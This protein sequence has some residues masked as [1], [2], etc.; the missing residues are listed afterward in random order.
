M[1]DVEIATA[2]VAVH[3]IIIAFNVLGLFVI[4]LGAWLRLAHL[5]LLAIVAGQALMGRACILTIWQHELIGGTAAPQPMIMH[6]LDGLIY[7]NIPIWVFSIIYT[8]VFLYVVAL[9]LL[10]PFGRADRS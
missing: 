8:A 4:P 1:P 9:S 10:V 6:W 7:Y 2:I 5:G 3:F